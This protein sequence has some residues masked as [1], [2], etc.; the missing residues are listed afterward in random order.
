[1]NLRKAFPGSLNVYSYSVQILC[2]LSYNT[3]A[4]HDFNKKGNLERTRSSHAIILFPGKLSMQIN[5]S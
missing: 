3:N 4:Y 2:N 5:R 1:M